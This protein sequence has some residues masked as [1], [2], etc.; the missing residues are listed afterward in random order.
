MKLR[1]GTNMVA[2]LHRWEPGWG[3]DAGRGESLQPLVPLA[4]CTVLTHPSPTSSNHSSPSLYEGPPNSTG[5]CQLSGQVARVN[6]ASYKTNTGVTRPNQNLL[7]HAGAR[8]TR[9]NL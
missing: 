1:A 5:P 9:R 8:G 7:I 3:R 2:I 6:K 4:L